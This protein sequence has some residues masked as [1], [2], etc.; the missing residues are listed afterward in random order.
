MDLT[1]IPCASPPAFNVMLFNSSNA[2]IYN[3]SITNQTTILVTAGVG[4]NVQ[5]KETQ[6]GVRMKVC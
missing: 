2:L 6:D 1:I 3:K 4:I 5:V